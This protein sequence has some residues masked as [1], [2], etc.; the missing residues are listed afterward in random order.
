MSG[1]FAIQRGSGRSWALVER[2]GSRDQA[3]HRAELMREHFGDR[4][5]IRVVPGYCPDCGDETHE[6]GD[7]R[8]RMPWHRVATLMAR[9]R[10]LREQP[11]CDCT[12]DPARAEVRP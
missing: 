10:V 4:I 3:L 8:A 6:P 7:C 5:T 1:G 2:A 9:G 12:F 11:R